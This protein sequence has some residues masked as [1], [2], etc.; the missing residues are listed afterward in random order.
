ML[1]KI[2]V[3]V[4]GSALSEKALP[5]ALKLAGKLT[6]QITL[7]RV[8]E[9]S[10]YMDKEQ[11]ENSEA[12]R[13][14]REYLAKVRD[15]LTLNRETPLIS[16]NQL[17]TKVLYGDPAQEICRY[18]LEEKFDLVTMTTHGKPQTYE[19]YLTGSVT[20]QVL[21]HLP[22]PVLLVRPYWQKSPVHPALSETLACLDEP[23]GKRFLANGGR[24]V[25]PLD[26]TDKAEAGLDLSFELAQKLNAALYLLKVNKPP[27]YPEDNSLHSHRGLSSTVPGLE[28]TKR[29]EANLYLRQIEI[30][31]EKHHVETVKIVLSGNPVTEI[32]A[33]AELM[34][35]DAL[36][37]ASHTLGEGEAGTLPSV[38][39]EV[40]R[41]S[42]IPVF[43]V[44]LARP[45]IQ[46][47]QNEAALAD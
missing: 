27:L 10:P 35:P 22:V 14:A 16:S 31:A 25:L 8:V 44:P 45:V 12:A 13:A 38:T 24:F 33:F 43:M 26:M 1:N 23:F 9:A 29:A 46:K 39:Q 34:G 5:Y 41:R 47:V 32:L 2:L 37:M 36:I 19:N 7:L 40:M 4:D 21:P 17:Q 30:M 15:F 6:L 20:R 3:P 28:L 11:V 18:A 42:H